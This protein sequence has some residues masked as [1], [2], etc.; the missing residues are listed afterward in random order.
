VYIECRLLNNIQESAIVA[1][2]LRQDDNGNYFADHSWNACIGSS[3]GSCSWQSEKQGCFCMTDKP[4]E[5]GEPGFCYN[6]WSNDPLFR[7]TPL[8]AP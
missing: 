3:C 4:G 5:P 2:K 6:I 8:K 1:V 7:S